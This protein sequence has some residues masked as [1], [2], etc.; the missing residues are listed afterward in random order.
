M[1]KAEKEKKPVLLSLL[2]FPIFVFP[3]APFRSSNLFIRSSGH[4]TFLEQPFARLVYIYSGSPCEPSLGF[5]SRSASCCFDAHPIPA[6]TPPPQ[7]SLF[8]FL[9]RRSSLILVPW[10]LKE[11]FESSD[12]GAGRRNRSRKNLS[13]EGLAPYRRRTALE[14]KGTQIVFGK[15]GVRRKTPGLR[16]E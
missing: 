7:P 12:R 16:E 4:L 2:V 13:G 5:A 14:E 8:S 15:S 3:R 6:P 11:D 9:P 1:S 10:K